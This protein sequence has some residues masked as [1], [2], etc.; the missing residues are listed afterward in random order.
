MST[1]AIALL[2]SIDAT[3]KQLLA[4]SKTNKP[5]EIAPDADLDGQY[6]D[7]IV[8]AQDP[9]DWTGPSQKGKH[10]SECSSEYLEL[11]AKR[12]DFFAEKAESTNELTTSRQAEGALQPP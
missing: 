3:L 9:R 6:G 12:L 8:K 1:E 10:F 5:I 2:K 11:V 4:L 7:P